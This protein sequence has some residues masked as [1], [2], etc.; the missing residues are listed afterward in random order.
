MCVMVRDVQH[1]LFG[2][3][4]STGETHYSAHN[5]VIIKT[6]ATK[7]SSEHILA[8]QV[9][10]KSIAKVYHSTNEAFLTTT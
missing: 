6:R 3:D 7:T 9:Y 8:Q 2:G 10:E 5:C 1:Q 4:L